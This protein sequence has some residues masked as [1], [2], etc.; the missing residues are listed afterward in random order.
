[1]RTPVLAPVRDMQ[2]AEDA[3]MILLHVVMQV[4]HRRL[5]D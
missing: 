1:V 3:H 5:Q 2:K 4:L